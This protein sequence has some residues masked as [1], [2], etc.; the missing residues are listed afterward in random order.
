M[1]KKLLHIPLVTALLAAMLCC[2]ASAVE[3][4]IDMSYTGPLDMFS[5]NPVTSN[6][7]S[8]PED[9]VWISDTVQYDVEERMYIYPLGRSTYKDLQASV[10]DGMITSG[11]V[12]IRVDDGVQISLYRNGEYLPEPNWAAITQPGDYVVTTGAGTGNGDRLLSFTI[13]GEQ[14]NFVKSYRMPDGFQVMEATL[15]EQPIHYERNY[16]DMSDEGKYYVKYRSIRADNTYEL[17]YTADFTPPVLALEAVVDGMARGPVDLSDLEEGAAMGV[18]LDGEPIGHM[19]ELTRSGNYVVK[20][21]DE[22]GN[23]NTYGF[24]IQVY[25]DGNS[26][27]FFGIVAAV[28]IGTIA[29]VIVSRK[30]L[31]VR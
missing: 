18:W 13:V 2:T 25:F 11:G 16:V 4:E 5:G 7:V 17:S 8:D 29:Y 31:R 9:L 19:G 28:L 26:L 15:N 1:R 27:I 3:I 12:V 20:V 21:A 30:R 6:E 14:C 10:M 24:T 23:M 22:A